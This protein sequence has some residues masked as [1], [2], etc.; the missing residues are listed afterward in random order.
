[1]S[2]LLYSAEILIKGFHFLFVVKIVL[3]AANALKIMIDMALKI[4]LSQY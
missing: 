2:G 1:M 4:L 3:I